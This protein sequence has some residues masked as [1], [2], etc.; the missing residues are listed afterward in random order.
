MIAL[1]VDQ[2]MSVGCPTPDAPLHPY[3]FAYFPANGV[4]SISALDG[5]LMDGFVSQ[6][7]D[8]QASPSSTA[9]NARWMF[10][11]RSAALGKSTL[12]VQATTGRSTICMLCSEYVGSSIGSVAVIPYLQRRSLTRRSCGTAAPPG[13]AAHE[14]RRSASFGQCQ[15]RCENS[16]LY[17]YSGSQSGLWVVPRQLN[18]NSAFMP[19]TIFGYKYNT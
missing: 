15:D 17:S 11:A 10:C 2:Y 3:A 18:G 4:L 8:V 5:K 9:L 12:F 19:L 6:H 7:G 16:V 1:D 13:D 14:L